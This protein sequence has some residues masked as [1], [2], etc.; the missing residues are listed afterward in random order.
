[1][2]PGAIDPELQVAPSAVEVCAVESLLVQVTEP[3]TGTVIG[4]GEYAVE[5]NV[6]AP[7]TMEADT[8]EPVIGA[9]D[10]G[11]DEPHARETLNIS[12]TRINRKL[13]R[14]ISFTHESS[15]NSLPSRPTAF[16]GPKLG[17]TRNDEL[18]DNETLSCDESRMG[19][20]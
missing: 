1:V 12:A 15:A 6:V 14:L 16:S 20:H 18:Q 11:E 2:A 19:L 8:L 7:A 10:D 9:G 4:F 5:V 3:P 17:N 13:I